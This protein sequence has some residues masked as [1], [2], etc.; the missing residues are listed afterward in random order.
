MSSINS[1]KGNNSAQKTTED[2]TQLAA[3]LVELITYQ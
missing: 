3:D 1:D 2:F